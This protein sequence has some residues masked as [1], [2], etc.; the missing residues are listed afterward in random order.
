MIGIIIGK[1]FRDSLMKMCDVTPD[2]GKAAICGHVMNVEFRKF[3]ETS[4]CA[5]ST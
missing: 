5:L 3:A 4:T 1:N 2:S